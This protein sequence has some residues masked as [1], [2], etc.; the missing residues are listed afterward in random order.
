MGEM[1]EVASLVAYLSSEDAGYVT[2]QEI[3]VD[4]GAWLNTFSLTR[5]QRT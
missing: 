3:G 1:D 4:G 5:K 2:G